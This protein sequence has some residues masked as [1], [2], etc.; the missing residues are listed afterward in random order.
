MVHVRDVQLAH[1]LTVVGA[2]LF[3]AALTI[4]P[5]T[6]VPTASA[7]FVRTSS[8]MGPGSQVVFAPVTIEGEEEK[9]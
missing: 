1:P 3:M 4:L 9:W 8:F 2:G 7:Q 5:I 6:Q